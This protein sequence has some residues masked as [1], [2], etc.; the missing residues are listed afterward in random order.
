MTLVSRSKLL[1]LFLNTPVSTRVALVRDVAE[2]FRFALAPIFVQLIA[3]STL[4]LA[5]AVADPL[6]FPR[7]PGLFVAFGFACGFTNT[8]TFPFALSLVPGLGVTLG[9][10]YGIAPAI[11][12]IGV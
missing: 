3:E 10:T 2:I 7:I 12:R 1:L 8:R 6:T 11:T 5:R 4:E 9:L